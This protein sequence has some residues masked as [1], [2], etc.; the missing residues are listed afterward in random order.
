[1]VVPSTCLHLHQP[2][3]EVAIHVGSLCRRSEVSASSSCRSL[4]SPDTLSYTSILVAS[5][6]SNS[7]VPHLPSVTCWKPTP[8]RPFPWYSPHSQPSSA[9]SSSCRRPPNTETPRNGSPRLRWRSTKSTSLHTLPHSA[10]STRQNRGSQHTSIS[11]LLT[12]H[13]TI[14]QSK[15]SFLT[16]GRNLVG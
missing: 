7:E 4:S 1:M 5:A 15:A 10:Q 9:L 14:N 13:I 16:Q 11:S 12:R 6:P 8:S 2:S 3:E